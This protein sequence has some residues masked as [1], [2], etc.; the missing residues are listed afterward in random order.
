MTGINNQSALHGPGD[1]HQ[2]GMGT[3]LTGIEMQAGDTLGGCDTC[4][5]AGF[6]GGISVDQEIANVVGKKTKLSSMEFGIHVHDSDDWSRMSYSGPGQPMP[7]VDDPVIAYQR[8]FAGLNTDPA[9]QKL[10]ND[11]RKLVL[12]SVLGDA[13]KLKQK[14]GASDKQ[15]LDQ[16]L[17]AISSIEAHLNNTVIVGGACKDPGQ[18]TDPGDIYGNENFQTIGKLQMDLLVMALTCDVTRVASLQWTRSVGMEV[19]DWLGCTDGHHTISHEPDDDGTSQSQLI[20]INNWYAKQMLYLIEAMKAV[21]EGNK[22]LFDNT[23]ILWVNELAVGNV[24]SHNDMRYLIAGSCGGKIPTGR[25]LQFS[26]DSH[27]NLLL[28]MCQAMGLNKTTFGNPAYC[29][30][31]LT[32]LLG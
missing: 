3:C 18:P 23:A 29:T 21:P 11:Q 1:D 27:N 28:S 31:P 10:L 8:L 26:G 30:G 22:T 14:L 15:K 6:A 32:G 17:T 9:G 4:P 25:H 24:H 2:R 20:A 19:F 12:D 7:P 16:H 13:N 5:P